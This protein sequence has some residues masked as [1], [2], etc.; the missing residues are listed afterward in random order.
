[1]AGKMMKTS[2]VALRGCAPQSK[3]L[4]AAT[5]PH[6]PKRSPPACFSFAHVGARLLVVEQMLGEILPHPLRE[7]WLIIGE[8]VGLAW[9]NQHIKAF[10]RLDQGIDKPHRVCGVDVVVHVAV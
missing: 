7:I 9:Q 5:S 8:A 10:V 2:R 1:M 3:N 6:S 4:D